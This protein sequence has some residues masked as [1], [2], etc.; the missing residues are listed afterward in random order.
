MQAAEDQARD[1]SRKPRL[2]S[3]G[4]RCVGQ[5][6]AQLSSAEANQRKAQMDEDRYVPLAQQQAITNRIWTTPGRRIKR[7]RRK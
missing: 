5:A 1:N 7:K 6:Q 2:N 3:P 4:P